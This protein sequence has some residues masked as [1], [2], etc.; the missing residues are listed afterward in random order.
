M[1]FQGLQ[2]ALEQESADVIA[3]IKQRHEKRLKAEEARIKANA[4]VL[5]E[6]IISAAEVEGTRAAKTLHQEHQ[7][8]A[9]AEVLE[10]KQAEL[11]ATKAALIKHINDWDDTEAEQL[12]KGLLKLL[13]GEAGTITAGEHHRDLLTKLVKE[14]H[15]LNK[16]TVPGGGFIFRT[17]NSEINLTI[18][19]LVQQLFVRHR[20]AIAQ[21]L[22]S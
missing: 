19:H 9:K 17:H 8:G 11:A 3:K 21:T 4:R 10:A 22:F 2:Q 14:P 20:A 16:T 5:D 13:P 7:L 6:E 1:S 12:L 18:E 15:Q